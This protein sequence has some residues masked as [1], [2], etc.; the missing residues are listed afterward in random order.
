MK[1]FSLF[2]SAR[3]DPPGLSD[4]QSYFEKD[5]NDK[6]SFKKDIKD[7]R[8][9]LLRIQA[10]SMQWLRD[11]TLKLNSWNLAG[12]NVVI[13]GMS[14]GI[15][16]SLAV[17]L[18]E[19]GANVYGCARSRNF[20]DYNKEVAM[21]DGV[22]HLR[23]DRKYSGT[24]QEV[25]QALGEDAATV[26]QSTFLK[27]DKKNDQGEQLY[28]M[29]QDYHP[30]YTGPFDVTNST[31]NN[32]RFD[33]VD[34]RS[35][36]H[37]DTYVTKLR[38]TYMVEQIDY[39]L[40]NA[41][42]EV[43]FVPIH[44]HPQVLDA[45]LKDSPLSDE[46]FL[47]KYPD[48]TTGKGISAQGVVREYQVGCKYFIAKLA[49][50]Y[51]YDDFAKK[52]DILLTSSIAGGMGSYHTLGA[53]SSEFGEY[54]NVKA[55]MAAYSKQ[56]RTTAG[57]PL[58]INVFYP[59]VFMANVN[60]G[61]VCD[62]INAASGGTNP[63]LHPR[64]VVKRDWR[65]G[66]PDESGKFFAPYTTTGAQAFMDAGWHTAS[67]S[68]TPG[69]EYCSLQVMAMMRK[70][71]P[72][73]GDQRMDV[74][75]EGSPAQGSQGLVSGMFGTAGVEVNKHSIYQDFADE[76]ANPTYQFMVLGLPNPWVTEQTTRSARSW[77]L[78]AGKNSDSDTLLD[79]DLV[80]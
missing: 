14:S 62:A 47:K 33:E 43:S 66:S 53:L 6:L 9:N 10:Q 29:P 12:K 11:E 78:D 16:F 37:L 75:V 38:D 41:Q 68:L 22:E 70:N 48:R 57:Q 2:R 77:L 73:S 64:K 42:T 46:E 36:K 65:R 20:F 1:F 63:C 28:K 76:S 80:S 54:V 24:A 31:F 58:R 18:A 26:A 71:K 13:T 56:M 4:F 51:G 79:D 40:I 74:I 67:P 44:Q 30:L 60:Y 32:I 23:E 50:T 39:L 69:A 55:E 61:W 21:T 59:G 19:L 72:L 15:G 5:V 3:V 27:L 7:K 8:W 34:V 35:H 45:F 25:A 17:R 52:T 49:N